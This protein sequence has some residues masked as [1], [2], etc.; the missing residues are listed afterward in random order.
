MDEP[1]NVEGEAKRSLIFTCGTLKRGFHNHTLIQDLISH[2]DVVYISD[3]VTHQPIPLVTSP[4]GI[5]YIISLP[6]SSHRIKGELYVVMGPGLTCLDDLEGNAIGHYEC[7]PI[8]VVRDLNDNDDVVSAEGYFAQ[9][10]FGD[11]LWERNGRECLNEYS[12]IEGRRFVLNQDRPDHG[13]SIL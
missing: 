2:K 10:S 12:K 3:Y 11:A 8:L 4:Q 7:L 9:R 5:P 13:R 6:R 1:S